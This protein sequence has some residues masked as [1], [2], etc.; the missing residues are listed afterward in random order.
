VVREL[1]NNPEKRDI[2]LVITFWLRVFG[3]FTV[4]GLL[5]VIAPMT[6]NNATT[7]LFI[8]IIASDMIFQSFE[9]VEFYF[10]SKVRAKIVLACKVI[11]LALSSLIKIY[12][13]LF[14][15]ELI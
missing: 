1:F 15:A 8:L 12:L 10:Q 11:Q 14:K 6:M 9:V 7:N 3:A 13:V 4:I 5:G 2:Y